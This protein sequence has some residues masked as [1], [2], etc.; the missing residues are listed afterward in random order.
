[1]TSVIMIAP[2]NAQNFESGNAAAGDLLTAYGAGGTTFAAPS[3]GGGG[4]LSVV[5]FLGNVGE[6]D[7]YA[8]AAEITAAYTSVV[9]QAPVNGSAAVL[10]NNGGPEVQFV[11]FW[12]DQGIWYFPLLS[13]I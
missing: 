1:M 3:G 4:G 7:T 9:G 2:L 12:A 8:T 11:V 5:P 13:S 10:V 6:P